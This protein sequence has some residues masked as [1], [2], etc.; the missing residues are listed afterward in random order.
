MPCALARQNMSSSIFWCWSIGCTRAKCPPHGA[1][2]RDRLVARSLLLHTADTDRSWMAR[3]RAEPRCVGIV[4]R[5]QSFTVPRAFFFF[6]YFF[7]Y[8]WNDSGTTTFFYKPRTFLSFFPRK[9]HFFFAPYFCFNAIPIQ[10][11]IWI[12]QHLKDL[13]SI[14]GKEKMF[15][16]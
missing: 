4:G 3:S 5:R 16:I 2:H 14:L 11:Q 13:L 15:K 7:E 10:K 1:A 12:Q 8:F 6:L 9:R